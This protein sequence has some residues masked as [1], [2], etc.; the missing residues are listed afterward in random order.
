VDLPP[1]E[2]SVP[3]IVCVFLSLVFFFLQ[4]DM[5]PALVFACLFLALYAVARGAVLFVVTG[6]ALLAVGFAAGYY[7]GV[8]ENVS[9]RVSMWLSPWNNAVRGGDQLAQSLWSFATGGAPG[10]GIGLGDPALI[11]AAHTDLV[12]SAIG[13]E[14]GF[15]GVLAIFGLYAIVLARS[16]RIAVRAASDYELFLALGLATAIGLQALVIASG[17]LGLAPLTGVVTPFIS[18]GRTSMLANF[19]MLA[20]LLSISRNA[21][22]PQRNAPFKLPIKLLAVTLAAC[23]AIV[24]VRAA[25]VQLLRSAPIVGEG[26][27]VTQ[28]DG[29]RRFEYNPR[30]TDLIRELPKGSIYDRNGLPLATSQWAEL[31]KHRGEYAELGID[32]DRAISRGDS[33]YYPLGPAMFQ[34]LGDVR[35]RFRWAA[36]NTSFVERDSARRLR[37]YDD[38]PT[39]VEV[40]D[41][42]TGAKQL[43]IRYD[44][45]ELVP[46]LRH[47]Y[48]PDSFEMRRVLDRP[49]D[50]HMSVDAGLQ[51]RI[52]RLL[53]RQLQQN[54]K[55]RGAMVVM[56]AETGDL[57]A[58]VSAPAVAPGQN[59]S[60][61]DGSVY[62]DRARYGLYPPGSTFKLITAMAALRI[63]PA[64]ARTTYACVRLPDN[65]VGA[66]IRGS[67]RP[68]HDDIL[69][70][71]PHGSVDMERALIV[72]CN[73]Y[74]AQLGTYNVGAA[75]LLETANLFRIAP[76]APNTATQLGKSL[77][78]ASYG[79]GQVVAS[80]FDMAR[81][82]ATVANG[83]LMPAGRWITDESNS[84]AMEPRRILDSAAA[85]LLSKYMREVVTQGTGR[86]ANSSPEPI[87]GKTGTAELANAPSHAWFVGFA[88]FG[89]AGRRI[90]FSILIENGQYGGSYAG[91]ATEIVTAARALGMTADPEGK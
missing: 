12:L 89:K 20:M 56:A 14:W 86:Q 63:N 88:P 40:D 13:E 30:L 52:T 15:L 53:D 67:R 77:A 28:A 32:I 38:R 27:L 9:G 8:P 50:V 34:L 81:V 57:L 65:R 36:P 84:R 80:P 48:E 60:P 70:K 82:A 21:A 44:Y 39:V 73:A 68:I 3:V 22:N 75:K 1:L 74:F 72:S 61:E 58:S 76:A 78:Q 62:L 64:L 87:A 10:T 24:I 55:Q 35:T 17:V 7:L 37:G 91:A 26:A 46:L 66:Y 5:G 45:R 43:T 19:A 33:R 23:G 79:Q 4:R 42:E 51:L 25:D 59:T 29:A 85:E 83:G 18:Y 2:S 16:F 90:A 69:D 11:P 41:P 31:E 6:L 47:R 54:G 49:R 71:T